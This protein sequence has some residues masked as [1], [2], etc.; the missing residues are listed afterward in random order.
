MSP[1]S[2]T[3]FWSVLDRPAQLAGGAGLDPP[4]AAPCR[5]SRTHLLQLQVVLQTVGVLVLQLFDLAPQIAHL[6][7]PLLVDVQLVLQ[8]EHPVSLLPQNLQLVL[9]RQSTRNRRSHSLTLTHNGGAA[10]R[11][12]LHNFSDIN[13]AP[14]QKNSA[15][16]ISGQVTRSG[17]AILHQNNIKDCAVTAVYKVGI[18]MKLSGVDKGISTYKKFISEFR[19]R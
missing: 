8:P 7:Q 18:D 12:F 4:L 9:N 10:H 6:L 17:Q 19:F 11:R 15:Q 16:G 2:C 13:I 5:S 1:W 3:P 14:L